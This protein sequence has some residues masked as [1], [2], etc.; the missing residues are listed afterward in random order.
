LNSLIGNLV[1]IW[2]ESGYKKTGSINSHVF[3]LL[4]VKMIFIIAGQILLRLLYASTFPR[5]GL[6]DVRQLQQ[7]ELHHYGYC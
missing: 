5:L 4:P 3:I 6:P 7:A 2:V 1:Q